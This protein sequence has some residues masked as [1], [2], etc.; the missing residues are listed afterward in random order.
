[1]LHDGAF[2]VVYTCVTYFDGVLIKYLV[3]GARRWK[4]FVYKL[5]KNATD[6]CPNFFTNL[7]VKPGDIS[8]SSFLKSCNMACFVRCIV[9]AFVEET[10]LEGVIV[11][12]YC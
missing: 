4:V 11:W 10:S 9:D 5:K 7:G 12:W 3:K 8:F 1:M 6:V 2:H